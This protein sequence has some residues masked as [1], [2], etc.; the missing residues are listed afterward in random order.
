MNTFEIAKTDPYDVVG[1]NSLF[2]ANS[3]SGGLT[4]EMALPGTPMQAEIAEQL[5]ELIQMKLDGS[6][7]E[8]EFNQLRDMLLKSQGGSHVF[9]HTIQCVEHHSLLL[10]SKLGAEIAPD[11]SI[12][13]PRTL[14]EPGT[15]NGTI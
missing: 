15:S 8:E 3:D 6:L 10:F 7:S 9:Q 4:S 2:I 5:E 1:S 12:V 13:M 14:V 11:G